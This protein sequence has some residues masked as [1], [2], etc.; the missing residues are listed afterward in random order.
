MNLRALV[1]VSFPVDGTPVFADRRKGVAAPLA[2]FHAKPHALPCTLGLHVLA[3]LP[4]WSHTSCTI[5]AFFPDH[6]LAKPI[7][8]YIDSYKVNY[9]QKSKS[10]SAYSNP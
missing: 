2:A 3:P 1:F 5:Y 8:T 4:A 9:K 6:K 7:S 10:K